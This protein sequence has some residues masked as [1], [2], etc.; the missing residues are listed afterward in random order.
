MIEKIEK[1]VSDFGLGAIYDGALIGFSGGADSSAILHYLWKKGAKLRA[2]HINHMIRGSEADRDELFCRSVCEKYG[3]EFACYRIDVP[4][5]AKERKRGLEE[6][7]RQERYRIFERELENYPEYK[8][9]VTAHNANDNAET[10]LFN[11]ARGSGLNGI[12]GIK[13]LNGNIARPLIYCS[14]KEIIKYCKD[15]NIKYVTDST[16]ADT[17]YTRNRIRHMIIPELE[18]INPDFTEAVTRFS[19]TARGDDEYINSVCQSIIMENS[20][21]NSAK[22]QLL[23]SLEM[24]LFYRII[25]HMSGGKVDYRTAL[26]CRDFVKN[27]QAGSVI[28]L[29]GGISL[30]SERDYVCFLE[31][32]ALL[33]AEYEIEL[34]T[35]LNFIKAAGVA[36]AVDADEVPKGYEKA[37]ECLFETHGRLTARNR[38]DGDKIQSGKMTKKIKRIMC[39]MHIPSHKR[40]KYPIICDENGIL[41]LALMVNRDGAVNKKGNT[42]ITLYKVSDGGNKND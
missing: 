30:K 5:I 17:D 22:K 10:V 6:T 3:I 27:S 19:E 35:G 42:K 29:N 1:A 2:I 40:D 34:E 15:N 32:E 21:E 20:I 28:N 7:A 36:I 14:K 12:C 11:L 25:K 31:N 38:R 8:Y 37:G 4:E 24:P 41:S 13:A 39:D 26:I 23:T 33:P 16:N 18:K 9:I